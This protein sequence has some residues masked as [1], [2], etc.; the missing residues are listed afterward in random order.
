M[1]P[2]LFTPE[3]PATSIVETFANSVKFYADLTQDY[4]RLANLTK[5]PRHKADYLKE[6]RR[7]KENAEFY[8]AKWRHYA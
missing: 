8:E 3:K 7:A 2:D 6:A 1:E 5:N 4:I